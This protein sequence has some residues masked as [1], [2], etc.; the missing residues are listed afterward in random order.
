MFCLPNS[1]IRETNKDFS[2][3]GS[4]NCHT[5]F[6]VLQRIT[7]TPNGKERKQNLPVREIPGNVKYV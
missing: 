3:H 4:G 7:E 5:A 6:G 1:S 2:N